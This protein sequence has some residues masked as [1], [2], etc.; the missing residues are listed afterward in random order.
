MRKQAGTLASRWAAARCA[1][2]SFAMAS[3]TFLPPFLGLGGLPAQHRSH[4]AAPHGGARIQAQHSLGEPPSSPEQTCILR[5]Q[6]TCLGCW[7]CCAALH[8][9]QEGRLTKHNQEVS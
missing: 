3:S 9:H 1:G 7:A 2:L 5:A 4:A 8:Q 6:G